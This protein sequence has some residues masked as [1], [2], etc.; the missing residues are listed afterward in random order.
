MVKAT[1]FE[2]IIFYL[3]CIFIVQ[4]FS[5]MEYVFKKWGQDIQFFFFF[6]KQKSMDSCVKSWED[7]LRII[8]FACISKTV[9]C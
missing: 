9:Y 7:N 5:F 2:D 6:N 1:L 3:F 4:R 8:L